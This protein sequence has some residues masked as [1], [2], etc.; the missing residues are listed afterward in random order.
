MIRHATIERS[1]Q[2]VARVF[3]KQALGWS[4]HASNVLKHAPEQDPKLCNF[5]L[6]C[7]GPNMI[8]GLMKVAQTADSQCCQQVTPNVSADRFI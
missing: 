3:L 7:R 5:I 6:A 4:D 1:A 8:C 2:T